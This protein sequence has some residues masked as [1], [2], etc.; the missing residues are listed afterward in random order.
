LPRRLRAASRDFSRRI[1]VTLQITTMIGQKN[2]VNL[3][4]LKQN[5]IC[6]L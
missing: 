3:G 6:I 2:Q 5:Y 1:S 4:R